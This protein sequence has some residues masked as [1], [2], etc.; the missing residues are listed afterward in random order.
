MV[1]WLLTTLMQVVTRCKL[2]T[3]INKKKIK[4]PTR[5][6]SR[7]IALRMDHA[8]E[9]ETALK[10]LNLQMEIPDLKN[11]HINVSALRDSLEMVVP[12]QSSNRIKCWTSKPRF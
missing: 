3:L 7:R 4:L 8:P 6:S 5:S 12:Y 9:T 2:K 1:A 11:R 10:S